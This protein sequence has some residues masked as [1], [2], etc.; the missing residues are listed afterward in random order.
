MY[1]YFY[2]TIRMN[3]GEIMQ[4]NR[5]MYIED[6]INKTIDYYDVNNICHI[7]KRNL[8]IKIIS[9]NQTKIQ[10]FLNKK[11]FTDFFGI[12]NGKFIDFETKQTNGNFFSLNMIKE[13]QIKHII[14]I[15]NYGGISFIVL[16][17]FDLDTTYLISCKLLEQMYSNFTNYQKITIDYFEKNAIK[18]D[19]VFPGILDLTTAIN[20]VSSIK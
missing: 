17:F 10:G 7:E 2:F 19:L 8:P 9:K 3:I 18:I 13:H 20:K 16:H 11:S 14:K 4:K 1:F 6:L 5:G 15:N 12:I